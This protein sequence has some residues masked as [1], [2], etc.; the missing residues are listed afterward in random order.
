MTTVSDARYVLPTHRAVVTVDGPEARTFLQGLVSND[1][2]T[3]APDRAVYTALLTAQ[4]R[5]LHDMFIAQLD[6]LLVLDCEAE[7]RADLLKRL[8]LY[9]L[10]AKVTLADASERLAVALLFGEGTDAALGLGSEPGNAKPFSGGVAYVDPRIP[11]LGARAVLPRERAA[12][13]LQEAGF[14]PGDLEAYDRLRIG[15]GVPDGSRDLPVEKALLMENG[16]DGLNGIDWQKGC[17]IGQELTARMRYRALVRKRLL[18]VRIDGPVPSPGTPVMR[19]DKEAGEM[20][21]A[22][23][24]VGLALLK[25]ELAEVDSA[26]GALTAGAARLTAYR[27]EWMTAQE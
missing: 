22:V 6:D 11:T 2:D 24:G 20:R 25:L 8:S 5:F 16:F 21:S 27:P 9:K 15:L 4:G 10:R 17:Y 1:V 13:A 14:A 26:E 19:G 3:V 12:A 7:R 18:P 23:D